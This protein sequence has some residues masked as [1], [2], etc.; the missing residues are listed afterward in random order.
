MEN[1]EIEQSKKVESDSEAFL[2]GG[3]TAVEGRKKGASKNR[4][5]IGAGELIVNGT[6]EDRYS[7]ITLTF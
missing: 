5:R 6:E 4:R 3:G 2:L 7:Q 1:L